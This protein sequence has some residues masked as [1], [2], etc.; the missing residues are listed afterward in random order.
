[1]SRL[2]S[3]QKRAEWRQRL[4]R[5]ARSKLSVAEFCRQ[6][7]VSVP[8]F[9]H[10]RKRL[11]DRES[12]ESRQAFDPATFIPVQVTTV[13]SLHVTFPNGAKLELPARDHELVKI[14]IDLI[15]RAQTTPGDE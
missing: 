15:A 10:W 2:P 7:K 5:F 8:S 6:E 11:A 14:S 1:M 9:Y 3:P 13:E 4:R 12:D